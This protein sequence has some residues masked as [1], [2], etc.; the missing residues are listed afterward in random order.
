MERFLVELVKPDVCGPID[1]CGAASLV[2]P[3]LCGPMGLGEA[4]LCGR[5][6]SAGGA[7]GAQ[8]FPALAAPT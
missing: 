2:E 1:L 3:D 6:L 8:D 4:S 7:S 5:A